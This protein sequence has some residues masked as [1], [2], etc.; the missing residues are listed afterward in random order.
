M[1]WTIIIGV[2]YLVYITNKAKKRTEK[3]KAAGTYKPPN[4]E[5]PF[6]KETIRIIYSRLTNHKLIKRRSDK[7]V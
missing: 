3:Q 6:C 7:S 4:K 5:C 1:H 2:L